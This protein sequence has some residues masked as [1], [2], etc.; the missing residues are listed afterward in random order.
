[1]QKITDKI[2]RSA[3]AGEATVRDEPTA[4]RYY[5]SGIVQA[6]GYRYFAQRTA[7]R[8]GVSG[9]T[10]NLNDGRVEVYAIGPRKSVAALRA[11]LERG[12]QSARVSRVVE[13]EAEIDRKF[14]EGFSIEYDA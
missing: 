1:M 4:R 12:P 5:V 14:D 9:Y 11:E 6:V 2:A 7:E 10:R 8:L 3:A 13:E